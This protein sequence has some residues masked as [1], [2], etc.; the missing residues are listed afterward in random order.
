MP[1]ITRRSIFKAAAL[2][3]PA[4]LPAEASG[5]DS[6]ALPE[7]L[8]VTAKELAER[9]LEA[10]QQALDKM[11][12]AAP[13]G[14]RPSK[15]TVTNNCHSKASDSDRQKASVNA[16]I[17]DAVGTN[18]TY[19]S[20]VTDYPIDR[21]FSAIVCVT[22]DRRLLDRWAARVDRAMYPGAM[23]C[24]GI[25]KAGPSF[26]SEDGYQLVTLLIVNRKGLQLEQ[27]AFVDLK[28]KY[29]KPEGVSY[30]A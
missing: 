18:R 19:I 15:E 26:V 22:S 27:S 30:V 29:P 12:E 11:R 13:K 17:A 5:F 1:T 20:Y 23:D 7:E 2:A 8:P 21:H 24:Y 9:E 3:I 25:A 14:G 16:K 6:D 10:V 4:S 28:A